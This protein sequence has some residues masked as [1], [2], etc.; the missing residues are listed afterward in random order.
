MTIN[1]ERTAA[2]AVGITQA[3]Y[4]VPRELKSALLLGCSAGAT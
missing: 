4:P 3:V 1:L 2:P